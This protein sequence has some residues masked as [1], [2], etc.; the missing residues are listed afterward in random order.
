[1]NS[2][3]ITVLQLCEH[4]GNEQS[5]FHGVARSFELWIPAFDKNR[6]RVLLCSRGG[7][8]KAAEERFIAAGITPLYLGYGKF[9]PRNLL[10]LMQIVS[11]EKVDIIHAHGYG[12]CLWGRIAGM[13]MGKPVIVHERC[14]YRTVP[15]FMRPIEWLLG[16]STRYAFAVSESTRKFTVEKRYIS[17]LIVKVLY[18]GIPLDGVKK[19]HSEWIISFRREQGIKPGNKVLG[20]VSRLE[21]HK[22]HI[23]AFKA[24]QLVLKEMPNVYLWVVGDGRYQDVLRRWVVENNMEKNI[25][26]LGYR[27]DVL[28]VIQCFDVQLFPSHQEGTPNTLYEAMAIGNVPVASTADGQGEILENGKTALLFEPGD[29]EMMADLILRLFKDDKLLENIRNNVLVRIKDF[30]MRRTIATLE[31]TYEQ[32]M[33][34]RS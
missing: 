21:S 17:S 19:A 7:T 13:L 14:N 32:I 12:A 8:I 10:K 27:P 18:S 31:A 16:P 34:G 22:G 9:D 28:S 15:L 1:M 20:I 4:F 30:D 23:D 24:L 5:S 6:F 25:K 29:H 3:P 11:S 2:R 26:F 33:D